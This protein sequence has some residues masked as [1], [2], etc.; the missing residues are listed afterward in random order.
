M[1][2]SF[3]CPYCNALVP[4]SASSITGGR[5]L[6]PRCGET[7]PA[8]SSTG[9]A[10]AAGSPPPQAPV[11]APSDRP[12][13]LEPTRPHV[14]LQ[15]AVISGLVLLV[16]LVLRVLSE[17]QSTRMAFPF[18]FLAGAGGLVASGWLWYFRA[19]RSNAA[20]ALFV[21]SN[22][23]ALAAAV[24]PFALATQ[25]F[26]R[27][28]DPPRKEDSDLARKGGPGKEGAFA[29]AD[30]PALGYLPRESTLLIGLQ[31]TELLR[32][33]GGKSFLEQPSWGPMEATLGQVEKWTGLK[34]EAI[35]HVALGMRFDLLI[36][37]LSVAVQT[38]QP[39]DPASFGQVLDQSK[40]MKHEG[41]LLYPLQIGQLGQGAL[42]CV[43]E[44][45]LVLTLWGDGAR[46]EEVKQG[47][48]LQPCRGLEGVVE[49]LAECVQKRLPPG[50][51]AWVAGEQVP[52]ALLS[53]ILPF[54][55]GGKESPD[56]LKG[57]RTFSVGLRFGE[58]VT[59]FGDLN[60]AAEGRAGAL[61]ELLESRKLPGVGAPKVAG[62]RD[63]SSW[64]GFQ[65]RARPEA[66]RQ[67]L[68]GEG[69]LWPLLGAR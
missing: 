23:A 5:I 7:F 13:L 68:R 1:A 18:M 57:V 28:N 29:P 17:S 12:A 47:L 11:S 25:D 4:P 19:R 27:A 53:A 56:T 2:E 46:F 50:T 41:R 26:R 67:A 65:L 8:P 48:P 16:S 36:P 10:V 60:C 39:Y 51:L 33:P 49:P 54:A 35:D 21:L 45:V 66:L 59:L 9:A 42:W 61:R 37:R 3:P 40:P 20:T 31:L 14:A 64:V 55:R 43:S 34:R 58:D 52:G 30:L 38:R 15:L 44:R 22:M 24:L 6:C 63:G 32:E 62:G 69:K